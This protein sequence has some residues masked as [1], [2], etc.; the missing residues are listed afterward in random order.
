MN[1]KFYEYLITFYKKILQAK[2]KG[3]AQD[4]INLATFQSTP[5]RIPNLDEQNN[6]VNLLDNTLISSQKLHDLEELKQSIL[7]Q[8]FEG[9]L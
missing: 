8:A 9:K 5:F 4:N 6:I 2:S 7:K 3:S 1:V